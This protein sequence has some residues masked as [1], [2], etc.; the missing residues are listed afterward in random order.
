[1]GQLAE[2]SW[3]PREVESQM[4]YRFYLID[5]DDHIKATETFSAQDDII[6]RETVNLVYD[7][8][9]DEFDGYEL[10]RSGERIAGCSHR[11]D[12]VGKI[13]LSDVVSARQE[14]ILDLEGRLQRTFACVRRIRKLWE[15][16]T[17]LRGRMYGV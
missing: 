13:K 12:A 11:A 10:G 14:N 8:C 1:M 6:A 3:A 16:A 17:A 4:H 5:E 15:T 9:N 7:A 2:P